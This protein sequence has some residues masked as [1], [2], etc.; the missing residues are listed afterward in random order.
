MASY[1]SEHC[2]VSHNSGLWNWVQ[3]KCSG[4]N[5]YWL[6]QWCTAGFEYED[7]V[8]GTLKK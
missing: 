7:N 6:P 3:E 2:N 8:Q 1:S 5:V 4:E